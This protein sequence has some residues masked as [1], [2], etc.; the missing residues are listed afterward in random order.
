MQTTLIL[1]I[2]GLLGGLAVGLQGPLTSIMSSKIGVV[3]SI[4]IIHL[5]GTLAA[6]LLILIF[7]AGNLGQWRT[8]P[9]YALGAGALGLVIL[10]AVSY[11]IPRLG[12]APTVTLIVAAQLILGMILDQFGLLGAHMRPIDSTRLLGAVV[13]FAGTWLMVK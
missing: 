1:I 10:S 6:L 9:W 13:L 7:G 2:L 8:V 4:F 12:V 11:T 5:G 3:G